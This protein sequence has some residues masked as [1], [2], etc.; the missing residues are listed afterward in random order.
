MEAKHTAG[1]WT[2]TGTDAKGT[3]TILADVT[4]PIAVAHTT[5][6]IYTQDQ[7]E[8]NARLIAAA[9]DLAS[10]CQFAMR[11]LKTKWADLSESCFEGHAI[12]KTL[13]AALAKTGV[14]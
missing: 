11:E 13:R 2:A 1:P 12:I 14:K 4:R 10:A 9:P 6:S 8:A 3:I 7:V 5:K